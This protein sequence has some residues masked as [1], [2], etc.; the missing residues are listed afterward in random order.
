MTDT[1]AVRKT[2]GK[3][4]TGDIVFYCCLLAFPVLQFCFLY[5]GV[6]VNSVLLAFKKYDVLTGSSEYIGFDNFVR[7]FTDIRISPVYRYGFINSLIAY[8]ASLVVG[9][10]CGLIFSY[11]IYKK[12]FASNFFKVILFAPSVISA[13]VL[14]TV[15]RIFV[16]TFIPTVVNKLF[17]T[18]ILGLLTE[19]DT[20]MPTLI[21]YYLWAGFGV[22]ILM[23]VG[24]MSNIPDSTI[25]AAR[26]DGV[27]PMR[28]FVSIV[29]P[30]IFSTVAVFFTTG[31]AGIFVNQLNLFSFYGT[32]AEHQYYTIGYLLY[33]RVQSATSY[34]EYPQLSALGVLITVITAPLVLVLRKLFNRFDPMREEK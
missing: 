15:F 7:L 24:A 32:N 28:E 20:V 23:Y 11:Y 3:R 12:K 10:T 17:N 30:Q 16:D 25:E 31:I 33:V 13:I 5:I 6:N 26:L 34:A 21:F 18:H 19:S 14:V 4:R 2:A 8:A 27:K 9:M 22:P 1:K 29:L